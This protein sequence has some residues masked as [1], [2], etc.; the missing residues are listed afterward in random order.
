MLLGPEGIEERRLTYKKQVKEGEGVICLFPKDRL[1]IYKIQNE[2]EQ[3]I[4][5]DITER[6]R[7]ILNRLNR[8]GV[9]IS[10][11]QDCVIELEGEIDYYRNKIKQMQ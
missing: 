1:T 8:I 7:Q 10:N 11:M 2:P 5:P 9:D 4:N 6:Y 3:A